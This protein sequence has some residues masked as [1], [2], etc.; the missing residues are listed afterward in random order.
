MAAAEGRTPIHRADGIT[1]TERYLKSLCDHTFLSLWSY[2][3]VYRD[4]GGENAGLGKEISDLMVVFDE[5]IILFS[6]KDCAFPDTGDLE[7]DWSRWFRRAIWRSAEQIWGAER[8]IREHPDRLFLDRACTKPFPIAL[9][10]P[11]TATFH[12]IVVAHNASKRCQAELG[13]SGSLMIFPEIVGKAHFSGLE[14]GGRPFAIGQ[15]SPE[16]GFVHVLGD[17]SLEV[18]LG[19][20]DTITDLVA[21]WSKKESFVCTGRL[22]AAAGEEDLL[23][24]Y[25]KNL[26][27]DGEHD[28]IIPPDVQWV[29]INEGLWEEFIRSLERQAQLRADEIS[30]S[31]DALIETFAQHIL[32]DTQYY[33]TDSE[34]AHSE[35]I[36]RFMAREPRTRRRL[37]AE[38]L[39]DLIRST[40]GLVKAARVMLPSRKGDPFYVFLLLPLLAGIPYAEYREARRRL[41]EAYCFVT[42]LRF[43]EAQDIVGIATETGRDTHRS[44][45]A[46]YYDARQWNDR[47]EAEARSLQ[48]DLGLLTQV[49][50]FEGTVKEYPVGG[51]G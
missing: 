35:C 47:D 18:V 21:Y 19:T 16:R 36:I 32:E 24:F 9:P 41:L 13:G 39:L 26:N 14:D 37:L 8:W 31:W 7:L 27:E 46:V 5:H 25:L 43:P 20:L 38:A 30:Y 45:D 33:T 42:R 3:G 29:V 23:A 50:K 4:Q 15:L 51:R 11:A 40:P 2:P 34:V 10:G 12:R 6:D 49:T 1:R 48:Q 28:F 17:V 22:I 44:E